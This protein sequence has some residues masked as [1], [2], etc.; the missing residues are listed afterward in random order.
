[1]EIRRGELRHR[2]LRVIRDRCRLDRARQ[3]RIEPGQVSI[4]RLGYRL[5]E[6]VT[7]A[8]V[9]CQPLID[10]PIVLNEEGVRYLT[11]VRG[12][13]DLE[14]TGRAAGVCDRA[15]ACR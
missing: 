4:L 14:L 15:G 7:Q 10:S 5:I 12:G 6:L 11:V 8:E 2:I 9:Y 3:R 1:M 13:G